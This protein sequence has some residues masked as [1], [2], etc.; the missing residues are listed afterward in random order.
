MFDKLTLTLKDKAVTLRGFLNKDFNKLCT[1]LAELDFEVKRLK[2][3]RTQEQ[4]DRTLTTST[5]AST[6]QKETTPGKLF[7]P[8]VARA[9]PAPDRPR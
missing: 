9:T 6:T 7:I 3:Q 2:T 8:S 4:K 1:H 5:A